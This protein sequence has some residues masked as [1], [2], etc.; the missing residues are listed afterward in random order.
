MRYSYE[1]RKY[2]KSGYALALDLLTILYCIFL[3]LISV[4]YHVELR[5]TI[6]FTMSVIFY[7]NNIKT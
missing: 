3:G 2:E 5:N 6:T 1:L 7:P 4:D